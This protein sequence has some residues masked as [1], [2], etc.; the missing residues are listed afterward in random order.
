M[1][2][3]LLSLSCLCMCIALCACGSKN[4]SNNDKKDKNISVLE[5][6]YNQ[7]DDYNTSITVDLN[8]DSKKKEFTSASADIKLEIPESVVSVFKDK[9]LCE[10][11]G[12]NLGDA[13]ENCKSSLVDNNLKLSYDLN[14]NTMSE[15]G[16]SEFNKDVTLE[17]AKSIL[18]KE[19]ST[20]KIK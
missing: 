5:C 4:G 18:E 13:Y 6:T 20:C 9:D 7:K 1:K 16:S 2:K 8:F 10:L 14:L 12:S 11:F 19:G 3:T 17:E 15:D